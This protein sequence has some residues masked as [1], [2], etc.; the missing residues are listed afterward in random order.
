[1]FKKI[2]I[3]NRGEIAV[4]VMQACQEMGIQT[5]AVYSEAD[6]FSLHVQRADEAYCI[7]PAPALESYL[8]HEAIIRVAR[9]CQAEAIHPGYGFLS[10]NAD[11]C[12]ACLDAGLV[13]IGP[14]PESIR[15]MGNKRSAKALMEAAGVPVVP[16]YYGQ[17]QSAAMFIETANAI[18]YPV[19]IKAAA[20]GG[21]KGMRIVRQ[22]AEMPAAIDGAK[23]EAKSA[24]KD[25]TVFIEKYIQ[26]PRHIEFQVLADSFGHTLHLHERECSIQR[27]H[28]KVLEEA[29][30]TVLT[31]ELRRKMGEIAVRAAKA[32]NYTNAGTIE[33]IFD[34]QTHSYYFLEMNTRLQVEHSVTEM[35]TGLDLVH[36]QIR[37][38]A[39]QRL[40]YAQAVIP[41]HGHSIEV[42]IYAEDPANNF[43][44]QT[45]I[46]Q[47]LEPPDGPHIR[48]DL[49]IHANSEISVYY[50]PLLAKLTVYATTRLDAIRR[51]SWAL[52]NYSILGLRHNMNFLRDVLVHP[53]FLEGRATTHFIEQHMADWHESQSEISD[54]VLICAAAIELQQRESALPYHIDTAK[55]SDFYSPW[56]KNGGWRN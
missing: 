32:V 51:L 25:D 10:E 18:G 36:W 13:F 38:A 47:V 23:R 12:Q 3:A 55:D 28:Q 40:P 2:L 30:S 16:G 27:R 39:G 21:G 34:D 11:F 9:Q 49:G 8:N 48:N 41:Q 46:I 7:G 42:R 33:F 5:V 26:N 24:F 45:G 6:N 22:E 56:Q 35:T 50:D 4:R 43:L 15:Q 53:I 29:P 54:E 14:S 31:Q 17:D 20:G 1:M 52:S 44:P 37:I 19:L